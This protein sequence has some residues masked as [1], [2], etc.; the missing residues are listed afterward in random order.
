MLIAS[1]RGKNNTVFTVLFLPHSSSYAC[2]DLLF[3]ALDHVFFITKL[4]AGP[5]RVKGQRPYSYCIS[6][7]ACVKS[8]SSSALRNVSVG[9]SSNAFW[10]NSMAC[11]CGASMRFTC[12]W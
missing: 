7:F 6:A 9:D 11:L 1:K 4:R 8:L 10:I 3:S 5:S 2:A 12:C